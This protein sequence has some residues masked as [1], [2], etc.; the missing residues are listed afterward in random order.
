MQRHTAI[1][2]AMSVTLSSAYAQ[3]VRTVTSLPEILRE[4]LGIE[5]NSEGGFYFIADGGNPS[6]LYSYD[7]TTSELT[8]QTIAGVTNRGWEDL[9][10]DDSGNVFIGDIG[11]NSNNR[12]DLSIYKIAKSELEK[13]D[14]LIA[15]VI[16]FEFEDQL[17]F[18]PVSEKFNY[19]C[20]S[21]FWYKDSI[22]L[23]TKNR[24]NP[25]DG[26]CYIYVLPDEPGV[27]QAKLRDS[28]HLP[29]GLMEFGWVTSADIIGD[30]IV[31]LS[32]ANVRLAG[33]F[34]TK[35]LSSLKWQKLGVGFSQKESVCFDTNAQT[36][37][38]SDEFNFIGNKL[39][40]L[41]IG[42]L[43][44]RKFRD[45]GK[46]INYCMT[47][48]TLSIQLPDNTRTT[49]SVSDL[50]GRDIMSGLVW[51]DVLI[52]GDDL[53]RTVYLIQLTGEGLYREFRWAKTE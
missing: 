45:N 22:Y 49:L 14:D 8:A 18:P 39:Y 30:S 12:R 10:Q 37:F 17:S 44:V 34:G 2:I 5:L 50:L 3:Q 24:A 11:N 20:E 36:I 9:T 29:L 42:L 41:K 53:P 6:S 15:E 51:S 23:F 33:G 48:S 26:W 25:Y 52:S 28:R 7:T 4:N 16:Y 35:P 46:R 38:I 40:E 21:M 1:W 47:S 13:S 31:L 27:Y 32:S 43:D 19:D